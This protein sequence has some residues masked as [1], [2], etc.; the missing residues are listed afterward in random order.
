MVSLEKVALVHCSVAGIFFFARLCTGWFWWWWT[1][2]YIPWTLFCRW[3][4]FSAHMIIDIAGVSENIKRWCTDFIIIV[5]TLYGFVYL[6][7][8]LFQIQ[9]YLFIYV[10][11]YF[12]NIIKTCPFPCISHTFPVPTSFLLSAIYFIPIPRYLDREC[13]SSSEAP[14]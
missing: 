13:L 4:W 2:R 11:T 14:M 1:K 10:L 6:V 5:L 8:H 3:V 7:F 9:T 12:L